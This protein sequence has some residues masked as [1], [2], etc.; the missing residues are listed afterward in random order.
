MEDLLTGSELLNNSKQTCDDL[1][2]ER[3]K[4][5]LCFKCGEKF[6]PGHRCVV[7]G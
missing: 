6:T 4:L 7:K 5:G 1:Y 2:E 3:K